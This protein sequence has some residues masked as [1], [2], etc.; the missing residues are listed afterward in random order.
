MSIE[1]KE[2][3][4]GFKIFSK[5]YTK[6]QKKIIGRIGERENQVHIKDQAKNL[7]QVRHS[8]INQSLI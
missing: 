4:G 7:G 5:K 2:K 3:T 6:K 1:Y 8:L